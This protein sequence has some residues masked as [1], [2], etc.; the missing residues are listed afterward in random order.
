MKAIEH[1]CI[2][3]AVVTQELERELKISWWLNIWY[4]IRFGRNWMMK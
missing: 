2:T 3:D 4:T 1:Y